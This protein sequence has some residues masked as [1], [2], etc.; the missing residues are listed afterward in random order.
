MGPKGPF[1]WHIVN[2]TAD[3]LV[4]LVTRGSQWINGK[5]N[6][7]QSEAIGSFLG[8]LGKKEPN[9]CDQLLVE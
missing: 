3:S 7:P 1:G 9:F 2:D 5:W 8:S 4:Q 6:H